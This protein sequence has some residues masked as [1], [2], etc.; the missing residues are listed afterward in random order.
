MLDN[1]SDVG[2]KNPTRP[3]SSRPLRDITNV[4]SSL[5]TGRR[6]PFP[7]SARSISD[8]ERRAFLHNLEVRAAA[9]KNDSRLASPLRAA[10]RPVTPDQS[11]KPPDIKQHDTLETPKAQKQ[12]VKDLAK[13][14]LGREYNGEEIRRVNDSFWF[15]S[16]SENF[17]NQLE[18]QFGKLSEDNQA[19]LLRNETFDFL[20]NGSKYT[21]ESPSLDKNVQDLTKMQKEYTESIKE[22][23]KEVLGRKYNGEEIRTVNGHFWFNSS[24]HAFIDEFEENI[25][26]PLSTA[27]QE[28]LKR[29]E[30][31]DVSGSQFT[32]KHLDLVHS[33]R[34]LEKL[35]K[36][37]YEEIIQKLHKDMFGKDVK[38]KDA[39]GYV[40]EVK[41]SE[42]KKALGMEDTEKK[43]FFTVDEFN[44][45]TKHYKPSRA[46]KY[47]NQVAKIAEMVPDDPSCKFDLPGGEIEVRRV[48]LNQTQRELKKKQEEIDNRTAELTKGTD[49]Y[50][51]RVIKVVDNKGGKRGKIKQDTIEVVTDRPKEQDKVQQDYSLEAEDNKDLDDVKIGEKIKYSSKGEDGSYIEYQRIGSHELMVELEGRDVCD[52]INNNNTDKNNPS[53][54]SQYYN[55]D[56]VTKAE[57][58]HVG[59][60]NDYKNWK[61]AYA[62]EVVEEVKGKV[63]RK[64]MFAKDE[65]SMRAEFPGKHIE[66]LSKGEAKKRLEKLIEDRKALS[67]VYDAM[68]D[69]IKEAVKKAVPGSHWTDAKGNPV[70]PHVSL[71]CQD[72]GKFYVFEHADGRCYY[73]R[74]L[75]AAAEHLN[76]KADD[77]KK[78]EIGK[79][80]L[81]STNYNRHNGKI[82]KPWTYHR[83]TEDAVKSPM[84]KVTR[85]ELNSD[86][87]K[88]LEQGIKRGEIEVVLPETMSLYQDKKSGALTITDDQEEY[89]KNFTDYKLV[90]QVSGKDISDNMKKPDLPDTPQTHVDMVNGLEDD[91]MEKMCDDYEKSLE[92]GDNLR[93]SLISSL[94]DGGQDGVPRAE[95]ERILGSVQEL[96]KNIPEDLQDDASFVEEFT[97]AIKRYLTS[98]KGFE[99]IKDRNGEPND[100]L[101]G[102]KKVYSALQGIEN[103]LSAR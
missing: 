42:L 80:G 38:P 52:T 57:P 1:R 59:G 29:G 81:C 101:E 26:G 9:H 32:I 16:S 78:L 84:C 4:S 69:K 36:K 23:A 35:H 93:E 96:S 11:L 6:T 102:A 58:I 47:D 10:D 13:E 3:S 53:L 103:I 28:Q 27:N 91:E 17:K 86:E 30:P 77:L 92:D 65:K 100:K 75:Y 15:N 76:I 50:G 72:L 33:V 73:G 51:Y 62:A 79:G 49:V 46:K 41:N 2:P 40:V 68:E 60:D 54:L 25:G 87:R 64:L 98:R 21:V 66:R 19:K 94:E 7:D 8:A 22:L 18:G 45:L 63:E 71:K 12:R 89:D 74:S 37:K 67:E 34:E 14:V 43:K 5:E 90:K 70:E 44:A 61:T 48:R 55:A 31:F 97:E 99:A 88:K 20:H 82:W 83:F 85:R 24:Y 95:T 39:Y 56:M